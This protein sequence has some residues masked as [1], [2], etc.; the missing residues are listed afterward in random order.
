MLPFEYDAVGTDTDASGHEAERA[1]LVFE[2][3]LRNQI[4]AAAGDIPNIFNHQGSFAVPTLAFEFNTP[5]AG[6]HSCAIDSVD[7]AM[8]A[9]RS[10]CP[11]YRTIPSQMLSA[12][13]VD[14]PQA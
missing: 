14:K 7:W 1:I 8:R 10:E 9:E 12:G 4:E 6:S 11:E 2:L 5:E 3:P 13:R